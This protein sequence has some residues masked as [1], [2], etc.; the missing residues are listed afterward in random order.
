MNNSNVPV[1]HRRADATETKSV[2]SGTKPPQPGPIAPPVRRP[3]TGVQSPARD[4]STQQM[5][6]VPPT[7][8]P[9]VDQA[10]PPAAPSSDKQEG[11]VSKQRLTFQHFVPSVAALLGIF[12]LALLVALFK[13]PVFGAVL[14]LAIAPV[15]V[16]LITFVRRVKV[17]MTDKVKGN[18]LGPIIATSVITATL[19]LLISNPTAIGAMLTSN[20]FWAAI[21]VI[22]LAVTLFKLQGANLD[23]TD[24]KEE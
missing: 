20:F 21:I 10:T 9:T 19:V 23:K 18:S 24:S 12:A 6:P 5:P 8:D 11:I 15:L 16:L 13:L 22:A 7:T 4:G 2:L 1:T 17:T 14:L 3:S